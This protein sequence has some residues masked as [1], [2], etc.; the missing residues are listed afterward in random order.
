MDCCPVLTQVCTI[1]VEVMPS[2]AEVE[3]PPP[4]AAIAD[5]EYCSAEVTAE[6]TLV[7]KAVR[8]DPAA[9]TQLEVDEK[10]RFEVMMMM[11][12]P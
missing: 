2:K 1:R 10:E 5:N 7:E 6:V 8:C 12:A 11:A 4:A 9:N 3:I